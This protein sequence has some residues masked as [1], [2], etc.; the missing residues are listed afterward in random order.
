MKRGLPIIF[1]VLS[2][3]ISAQN[4]NIVELI[5]KV[6]TDWNNKAQYLESYEDLKNLCKNDDFRTDLFA[7][8]DNIHHYDST[9]YQIAK[10]KYWN[11][12]DMEAKAAM[13][14]ITTL[15]RDF[16]TKKFRDFMRHECKAYNKSEHSFL[17][18]KGEKDEA[19][20]ERIIASLVKY[21]TTI[22]MQIET[23]DNHAR[24]LKIQ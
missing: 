14:D 18:H 5:D 22:T 2:F 21:V 7:L 10:N 11:D 3:D 12:F 9:L 6:K 4:K 1:L 15:E 17:G 13:D 23:I 20:K 16:T 24:H 8:M 19:E